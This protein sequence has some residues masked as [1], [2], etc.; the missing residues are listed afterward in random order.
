MTEQQKSIHQLLK[1]SSSSEGFQH[2]SSSSVVVMND[3]KTTRIIPNNLSLRTNPYNQDTDNAYISNP[4]TPFSPVL[5]PSQEFLKNGA[6]KI[7]TIKNWGISTYKCTRQV[8][9]EKVGKTDRTANTEL[10]Q[11]INDLRDTQRKYLSIL[12]LSRTFN[13]HFHQ[14]VATQHALAEAFSD[15]AQKSPELQE[16]FLYNAETQR[17]LTKNGEILLN[18]INFF[19]SSVNTLCNKTIEDTLI[20]IRQFENARIEFDAWRGDVQMS[21]GPANEE[22]QRNFSKHKE[23]YEKLKADVM[24][25][26]QFLDENR[27]KVMH[28]QM[29]LFHNAIAA[30]F[31]GNATLLEATI[32]QFSIKSPNSTS[33]SFL[34]H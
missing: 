11:Q 26:M 12:R 25:K 27:I 9:L 17:N 8:I 1:E 31:S 21:T 19:I 24:V 4:H 3:M 20:T 34:E 29:L 16:E 14:V 33:S 6:T 7:D 23:S 10:E 30:Y 15:L 5:S 32:K 13:N 18:A 2:E 22:V 28:K